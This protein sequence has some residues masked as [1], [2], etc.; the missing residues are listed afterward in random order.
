MYRTILKSA[1]RDGLAPVN[2]A[3]VI[4]FTHAK[5]IKTEFGSRPGTICRIYADVTS[6]TRKELNLD[7][8]VLLCTETTLLLG[9]YVSRFVKEPR[10]PGTPKPKPVQNVKQVG[11]MQK[12]WIGDQ[13]NRRAGR[14]I[15]IGLAA[16]FLGADHLERKRLQRLVSGASQKVFRGGCSKCGRAAE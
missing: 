6:K 3:I 9:K 2:R 14:M 16:K 11:S 13:F 5:K 4:E 10:E 8:L 12:V 1:L 15:A 7:E